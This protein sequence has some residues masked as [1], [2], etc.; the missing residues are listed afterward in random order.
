V[1]GAHDRPRVLIIDDEP[2]IT[3]VFTASLEDC[4]DVEVSSSGRAALARLLAGE[5]YDFIF[6]DLMMSDLGGAQLYDALHKHAPGRETELIFMTGGVYD[7]D[8]ADFL[9]GV[10]NRCLDKPF[11]IRREVL[12]PD[13]D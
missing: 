5:R 4:C 10:D 3:R 1:R 11:D 8:V 2:M 13:C 9:A 6:C 12:G 7:P